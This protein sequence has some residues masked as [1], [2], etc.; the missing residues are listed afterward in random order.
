MKCYEVNAFTRE[1]RGGNPAAVC[2]LSESKPDHWKQDLAAYYNFSETA[3]VE[4]GKTPAIRW[5]T[6]T[7]EVNLCG[8]A[9]LA[10]A[11]ILFKED[12]KDQTEI[13]F[14]SKSGALKVTQ[15]SSILA[16]DF[17][18][19]SV[20]PLPVDPTL[21]E[22]LGCALLF[23][24]KSGEDFLLEVESDEVVRK[25]QPNFEQLKAFKVRGFSVSAKD[26]SGK[27]DFI[28]RFFAPR[29]GIPEDPVTGSAHCSLYPYWQEKLQ[30]DQLFAYQA[31]ERG[32]E[33]RLST[34]G[35][36]RVLIAGE[37]YVVGKREIPKG[38]RD[39]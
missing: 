25:L 38:L 9:T 36:D 4:L 30:K 19:M 12:M 5:F 31:S 11:S 17:P 13:M 24:A 29:M 20:E 37:A 3:F 23:Q 32:G 8:H 15:K 16:L 14:Q 18:L 1:A 33:L 35:T 2:L 7:C 27:Y 39:N 21:A 22:A 34:A 26:S 28:S 10:A 6:P